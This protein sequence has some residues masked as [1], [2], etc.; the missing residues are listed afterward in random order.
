[1]LKGTNY[2]IFM[3]LKTRISKK[4]FLLSLFI[5]CSI[6]QISNA[7]QISNAKQLS[8][9]IDELVKA[10]AALNQF[11]GTLLVSEKGNIVYQNAIGY[12]DAAAKKENTLNSIFQ[13]GSLTKTF[14]SMLILKLAETHKLS[15]QDTIS[16]YF[17]DFPPGK[18][19]TI[20]HLLSHSSGIYESFRNPDYIKDL[21][22]DQKI[23]STHLMSYFSQ[24]PLDFP[25]G[26]QFSYCNSG[27]N[28]LGLIIE[29]VTGLSYGKAV[30]KYIFKPFK[31]NH[32]GYNYN[33]LKDKNKTVGYAYLS[34]T[35]HVEVKPWNPDL[36]FSTGSLYS[37]TADLEKWYHVLRKNQFITEQSFSK[38]TQDHL[39]GY[40]YGWFIDSINGKKVINHGGNVEGGSSYFMI[41]PENDISVILLNNMT[42]T[43]LERIGNAI[44]AIL[45]DK[46][47]TLPKP[48]I[49]VQLNETEL[50]QYTGKFEVAENYRVNITT[51]NG[52]LYL[53]IN[54]EPVTEIYTA[55]PP[56]FFLKDDDMEIS[57]KEPK[58]GKMS[59]IYLKKGL[60]SK[61]GER[62][63]SPL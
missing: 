14:T 15:I 13:I 57:F 39:G 20:E 12:Q 36:T 60:N 21:N 27:Y 54:Q 10:Y 33:T 59:E 17:P 47:Y 49:P 55:K 30:E 23:A 50:Q 38:A 43:K 25:P 2:F 18:I 16:H 8:Q 22:S 6:S 3:N 53:Q 41:E 35:R 29:K 42:S 61:S 19:I 46:P 4:T 56:L 52:R 37:T 7:Q 40:G 26:T 48:K 32:S 28:L 9:K 45:L 51:E 63:N 5:F 31:M 44:L 34:N 62:I 24:E 11:N 1:M 58:E